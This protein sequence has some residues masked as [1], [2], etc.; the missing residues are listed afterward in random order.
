MKIKI[1]LMLIYLLLISCTTTSYIKEVVS[2]KEVS[3]SIIKTYKETYYNLN[4]PLEFH[5]NLNSK[6]LY[7][8]GH[9]YI[10]GNKSMLKGDD[11]LFIDA[12]TNERF[13]LFDRFGAYNYPKKIYL[14]DRQLRLNEEQ[15][16]EL[17]KKYNSTATIDKL[18]TKNDTISLVSYSQYR[19]DNPKFLEEMRK[20][21]DSLTLV[22]S[23][24]GKKE[25]IV[26]SVKINW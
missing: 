7:H 16:L 8:V 15:V 9:Y 14:Y 25:N 2:E 26:S 23:K 17:I 12:S 20:V 18:Q 22:I 24:S 3:I 5:L 1:V 11:Y 6:K 4:V 10:K 13:F 19:K 21:P